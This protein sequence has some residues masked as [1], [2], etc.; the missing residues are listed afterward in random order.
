MATQSQ[1][2]TDRHFRGVRVLITVCIQPALTLTLPTCCL[3]AA[4]DCIKAM[5]TPD[6]ERRPTASEV[7][8]H[9]WLAQRAPDTAISTTTLQQLQVSCC[10]WL[11]GAQKPDFCGR[12]CIPVV[13]SIQCKARPQSYGR[14]LCSC[15][16]AGH[17]VCFVVMAQVFAGMSR[18][19]RLMLGVM[20]RSLTGTEANSL[21][22]QFLAFDSDYNGT[23]D[24]QE[25]SEAA[26]Q[27]CC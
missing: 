11:Y 16:P 21:L 23:L 5:L 14:A 3:Q 27:V 19:R 1:P 10:A 17:T 13:H 9:P 24:F 6:P 22:S 18:A 15:T 2:A 25:L 20:A 7:L 12:C 8:Q 4:R 26:K